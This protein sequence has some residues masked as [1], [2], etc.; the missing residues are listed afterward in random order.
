V[1]TWTAAA[2]LL[3]PVCVGAESPGRIAV[4]SAGLEMVKVPVAIEDHDGHSVR[5]LN[6]EDFVLNESGKPQK[7]QLFARAFDNGPNE[8]LALDLALLFDTSESMLEVLKLSQQAAVRFLESVPRARDLLV[9]FFDQDIRI[10]RYQ[11][12]QQQA[13][14]SQIQRAQSKGNTA[15]RD[16][17]ATGLSR[18]GGGP[19]RFAMVVFSDGEDTFSRIS[20]AELMRLVRSS[21]VTIYPIM[22]AGKPSSQ[23]SAAQGKAFMRELAELSGGRIFTVTQAGD[24]PDIYRMI[25][26]DLEGQYVL[27]FVSS[28]TRQ[29]GGY[30]KLKVEVK[31][32]DVRLRHREGYYAPMG[33]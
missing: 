30:R 28:D 4:F 18:A 17:I 31:R 3:L 33:P 19:G 20:R 23:E 6:A 5:D 22:F 26:E 29:D 13:L 8:H 11:S 7:I 10:S 12:G 9:A 14:I 32:K 1:R 2:L 27:G 24:L 15:L 21:A 16:A 25:V